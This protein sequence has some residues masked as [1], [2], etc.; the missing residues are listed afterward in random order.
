MNK[1]IKKNQCA[2]CIH[3]PIIDRYGCPEYV[4]ADDECLNFKR[5]EK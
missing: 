5:K 1:E 3:K 4:E 2:F